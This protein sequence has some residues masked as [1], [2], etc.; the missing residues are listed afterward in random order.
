MAHRGIFRSAATLLMIVVTACS[1]YVFLNYRVRAKAEACLDAISRLKVGSSTMTESRQTVKAWVVPGVVTLTGES[2][3]GFPCDCLVFENFGDSPP[4]AFHHVIL[5]VNLVYQ[6]GVL[7]E[8][9][10]WLQQRKPF[11]SMGTIETLP[12][13]RSWPPLEPNV[14][15]AIRDDGER[16]GRVL[17]TTAASFTGRAPA[18]YRYTPQGGMYLLLSPNASEELHR[19]AFAFNLGCMTSIAGCGNPDQML[20]AARGLRAR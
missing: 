16:N 14:P 8:K 11:A 17:V 2:D 18:H 1:I 5:Y 15:A 19:S 3:G 6:D 13:F 20:P 10:I 12:G 7:A 4:W 9:S